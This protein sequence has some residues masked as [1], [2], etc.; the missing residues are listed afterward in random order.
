[1]WLMSKAEEAYK[2]TFGRTYK[3]E[4]FGLKY[5]VKIS[6]TELVVE[7]DYEDEGPYRKVWETD[8]TYEKLTALLMIY[9]YGEI[10]E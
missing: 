2:S 9:G 7:Q 8:A 4:R 10:I 6:I 5:K 3:I 1:M